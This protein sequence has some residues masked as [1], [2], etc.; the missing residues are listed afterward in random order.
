[1]RPTTAIAIAI[2]ITLAGIAAGA[3]AGWQA[4]RASTPATWHEPNRTSQTAPGSSESQ[5]PTRPAGA[6][7]AHRIMPLAT[8]NVADENHGTPKT[9]IV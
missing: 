1:M 5:T 7:A 3:Y 4:Y 6:P 9:D 8:A 2:I